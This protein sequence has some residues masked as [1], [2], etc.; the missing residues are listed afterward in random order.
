MKIFERLNKKYITWYV[1]RQKRKKTKKTFT[2]EQLKKRKEISEKFRSLY[3]FVNWLNTK[4]LANRHERK[5]FW[6]NV[7]EGQP[8]LEKVLLQLI[9]RYETKEPK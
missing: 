9:A 8:V 7:K 2:K 4:G 5:V 6:K 1:N 3:H